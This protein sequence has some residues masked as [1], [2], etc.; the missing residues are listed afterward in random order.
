[1]AV[2]VL[3]CGRELTGPDGSL[4][5]V[6]DLSFAAEFPAAMTE[7]STPVSTLVPFE[8]LRVFLTRSDGSLALDQSVT[9]PEDRDSLALNLT[10]TLSRTAPPEGELL[11]LFLRYINAAGD[12]VFSGG[13]VSVLAAPSRRGVSPPPAAIVPV[14]YTGPG[15]SAVSVEITPDSLEIAAGSSFAFTA[16]A[17]DG[18][19]VEVAGAPVYFVVGD[20]TLVQLDALTTGTGLSRGPRG[21][22]T[23]RAILATNGAESSAP[24]VVRPVASALARVGTT[25]V[26]GIAGTTLD[27]SVRVRLLAT[28]GLPLADV[29]VTVA[30][31]GGGVVSDSLLSTDANGDVAVQWT[32]GSTLAVGAQTLTFSAAGVDPLVL[33]ASVSAAPTLP[34]LVT[35]FA[36]D[37]LRGL[38]GEVLPDS[39]LVRVA[40]EADVPIVGLPVTVRVRTGGGTLADSIVSTDSLGHALVPAWTL[41]T[42]AGPNT[43]EADA[44]SGA[45][46][47][48][49]A[50]G[51]A[52]ALRLE[53]TGPSSVIVFDSV[54]FA[55]YAPLPVRGAAWT[56]SVISDSSQVLV[57]PNSTVTI[58]VG[59]S[60]ATF[61]GLAIGAG[62]AVVRVTRAGSQPAQ[63][64]VTALHEAA[65]ITIAFDSIAVVGNETFPKP[66]T[67]RL[68]DGELAYPAPAG[69]LTLDLLSDDP[70]CASVPTTVSV[71]AGLDSAVI[72]VTY[73]GGAVVPCNTIVRARG[74][75]GFVE[76]TLQVFITQ[77][78]FI[79]TSFGALPVG[80]G[81]QRPMPITLQTGDHGGVTLR[82]AS[83][84]PSALLISP[85]AGTAGTAFVDV[86]IPDGIAE[87]SFYLQGV[88]G[89]TD[90]TVGFTMTAPGFTPATRNARVLQPVMQL[91][92][93]L[94]STLQDRRIVTTLQPDAPFWV[95]VGT[96]TTPTGNTIQAQAVRAGGT[97]QAFT[98]FV[99]TVGPVGLVTGGGVF[100]TT[101]M[102]IAPG[103]STTPLSV[104]AGGVALRSLAE[105]STTLRVAGSFRPLTT[106]TAQ[107]GSSIAVTVSQPAITGFSTL[108][109]FVRGSF[110]FGTVFLSG[111]APAGGVPV[112]VRTSRPDVI[113]LAADGTSVGQPDSITVVVPEGQSEVTLWL[114]ALEADG[115]DTVTLTIE[116][117]GWGTLVRPLTVYDMAYQINT[118][119]FPLT[120]TQDL[121][122][123]RILVTLNQ[124]SSQNQ[125]TSNFAAQLRV[126]ATPRRVTVVSDD[127]SVGVLVTQDGVFDS[128]DVFIPAGDFRSPETLAEG[129]VLYR[130]VGPG[131][132]ALRTRVAGPGVRALATAT[133]II[134]VNEPA[135]AGLSTLV[136]GA[137]LQRTATVTLAA[138]AP[139]GGLPISLSLDKPGVLLL[140]PDN[141]TV[142]TETLDLV[143]PAGATTATLWVQA[144]EVP[145]DTVTLTASAPGYLSRASQVVVTTP[146]VRLDGQGFPYPLFGGDQLLS[147]RVGSP[148]TPGGASISGNSQLRAGAAPLIATVTS[149]D[150]GII[151]VV[152]DG[153]AGGSATTT[154]V[155]GANISPFDGGPNTVYWRALALGEAQLSVELPGFVQ[156]MG[157]LGQ[158]TEIYAPEIFL[159][160]APDLGAGLAVGIRGGLETFAHGGVTVTVLSANPSVAR[161]SRTFDVAGTDSIVFT[162]ADS[163]DFFSFVVAGMEAASGDVDVIVRIPGF[164]DAIVPVRVVRPVVDLVG[165]PAI[166]TAGSDDR[167]LR[168]RV[169]TPNA[170]G[171]A[172]QTLQS[173]RAGSPGL[174]VTLTSSTPSA[175]TVVTSGGTSGSAVV[176]IPARA[177]ASAAAVAGGGAALRPV[178]AG[179][180]T[181]TATTTAADAVPA[182]SATV[183]VVPP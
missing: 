168:V 89:I 2:A 79:S 90:Q 167:T 29:P 114:N 5:I 150:P 143:V 28:D 16:R 132:H 153:T 10:V 171:T 23:L 42:T 36:P 64:I 38:V 154:I 41:G 100:D 43:I 128:V 19:G 140:A 137:G 87:G 182:S 47:T 25:L 53:V 119:S 77:A 123:Q 63:A 158:P 162:L 175:A 18:E 129:A 37:S 118:T 92:G 14:T 50:A 142:G 103:D 82:I 177:S 111:I 39:L 174:A 54:Y 51:V 20:T 183:V 75:A 115:Q 61:S 122:D 159:D 157:T 27:D 108:T 85:D 113:L 65:D 130:A 99:E 125:T 161:V 96:A 136:L 163:I 146:V 106:T 94:T 156:D 62:P 178:A 110:R 141:A 98:L 24:L 151:Q 12:T 104:A 124:V 9:L 3:A 134:A 66:A 166:A 133:R 4:R 8:R 145:A 46:A 181:V 116:T 31:A 160:D 93:L 44:G 95:R 34:A 84:D 81:L 91:Q 173:V 6:R 127:P 155:A 107:A 7:I 68:L 11:S 72:P 102:V 1:M 69:G 48:V 144:L 78:P 147:V 139:I 40:D 176:T 17:L 179:T 52:N 149:D 58:P 131:T 169:G 57:I 121:A 97:Q 101:V 49:T 32:L 45:V 80:S 56:I 55:V 67:L 70:S 76:A 26:A 35:V 117:D 126:G 170:L 180:T 164:T 60:V 73:G 135:I 138:P 15:A 148:S 172:L 86:F 21:V 112:T 152:R 165:V 105:G 88:E 74:P 83:N 30:V 59:D 13:P 120:R 22:T 109:E 33:A 71:A